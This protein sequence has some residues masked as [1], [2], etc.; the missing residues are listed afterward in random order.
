M[1]LGESIDR[2]LCFSCFVL[3]CFGFFQFYF[4][5]GCFFVFCLCFCFLLYSFDDLK[6]SNY[7]GGS[8]QRVESYIN[9]V[10]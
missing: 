8:V 1:L 3:F 10:Q 4:A 6:L 5:S 9:N 2:Y 7:R